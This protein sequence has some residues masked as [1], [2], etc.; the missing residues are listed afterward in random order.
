MDLLHVAI[1]G[2]AR[3]AR[4]RQAAARDGWSGGRWEQGRAR[5]PSTLRIRELAGDEAGCA[6]AYHDAASV[7]RGKPD[8]S[9]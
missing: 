5:R 6:P 8:K 1:R 3:G 2:G 7:A 9:S 4:R